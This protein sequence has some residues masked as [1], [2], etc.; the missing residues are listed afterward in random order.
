MSWYED[1]FSSDA[2]DLVYEHRDREEAERCI[3]L[4]EREAG[5]TPG[6]TILDVGCGRGRH[7]LILAERG[8]DV[9]GLDLS[10]R[11]I[12]VA[13]SRAADAG[14]NVD[15][16]VG[17]MREPVG[18]DCVDGVVNLF[19]TFGYFEDDAD[20][21][22]ALRAMVTALRP[23]GWLVQDFL[24]APQ[25]RA[26]LVP[27]DG[28]T[29]EA[30]ITIRQERSIA[31]GRINKDIFLERN[32]ETHRFRE[33][34]RLL[35]CEDLVRMHDAAGLTVQSVYGTYDGAPRTPTTPRCILSS[36]LNG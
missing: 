31:D 30:G 2:Y 33:S 3:D 21:L 25:V 11:A 5:P 15:F 13:R 17:D 1:W 12:D 18:T 26:T 14:L 23:G 34:V 6:D 35:T 7:A 19:T 28:R 16:R 36:T 24:N 29:T 27:E 10:E 8:Y 4:I 20:N 22:R 9:I 32:G